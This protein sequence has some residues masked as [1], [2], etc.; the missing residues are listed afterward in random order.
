M[1]TA[2]YIGRFQPFHKAHQNL[3]SETLE[4]YDRLIVLIGSANR[5]RSL[6]N[7]FVYEERAR[8]VAQGIN[9]INK[10]LSGKHLHILLLNDTH[11]G[12]DAWW[13]LVRD[14]V[15]QALQ[16]DDQTFEDVT[17]VGT[18]KDADS[19]WLTS[20]PVATDTAFEVG[21]TSEYEVLS[22][23]DVREAYFSSV[24][25][26]IS[27]EVPESTRA[28]LKE[29]AD[30]PAFLELLRMKEQIKRGR[31]LFAGYP[32]PECLRM[33]AADALATD[34]A[35]RVLMVQRR[36]PK[37]KGQWALPGGHVNNDETFVQ[38]AYR[39]LA[40]ETNLKLSP[41]GRTRTHLFDDRPATGAWPYI[42]LVVQHQNVDIHKQ[43]IR[44]QDDA[45]DV[46]WMSLEVIQRFAQ[47][48]KIFSDHALLIEYFY[49][50]MKV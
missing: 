44:A 39:E 25:P 38:G 32:F 40:E 33:N 45:V 15:N 31:E 19:G 36:G 27:K 7:P 11:R 30:T 23:T 37:G 34:S 35:N 5:S 50:N 16:G 47:E 29:F 24:I 48:N 26:T 8:M 46:R 10:D 12:D 6:K 21:R 22:A 17:V 13:E 1:K 41:R 2:V 20:C 14:R 18:Y 28:F 9:N 4:T 49:P 43:D 3:I 42:T